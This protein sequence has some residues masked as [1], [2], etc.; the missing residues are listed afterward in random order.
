MNYYYHSTV[1]A[2]MALP[3]QVIYESVT[4]PDGSVF[5]R[6]DWEHNPNAQVVWEARPDVQVWGSLFEP[7]IPSASMTSLST[8]GLVS[9]D[10]CHSAVK[11]MIAKFGGMRMKV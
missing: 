6:V 9:T 8:A 7:T 5:M 3:P 4:L 1:Q 2:V 11:K 10:S